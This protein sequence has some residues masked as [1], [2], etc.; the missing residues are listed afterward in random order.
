MRLNARVNILVAARIRPWG[1][2]WSRKAGS[3]G[4]SKFHFTIY[5]LDLQFLSVSYFRS[6]DYNRI[7]HIAMFE[8]V[9]L[10][11]AVA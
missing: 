10:L 11:T 6:S 8:L 3:C 9:I 5:A 1:P 4:Q 2:I 7:M